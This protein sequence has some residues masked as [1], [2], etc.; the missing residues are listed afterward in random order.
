MNLEETRMKI[1][2]TDWSTNL[3]SHD[4]TDTVD[5]IRAD[6]HLLGG[7]HWHAESIIELYP[8]I[9]NPVTLTRWPKGLN[10]LLVST[11]MRPMAI[12]SPSRRCLSS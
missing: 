10:T 2:L 1:V 11:V 12:Y 9:P 3:G 6:G 8:L 5:N 4:S 7:L